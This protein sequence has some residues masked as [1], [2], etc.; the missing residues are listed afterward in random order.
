MF[1]SGTACGGARRPARASVRVLALPLLLLLAASP[2]VVQGQGLRVNGTA[3]NMAANGGRAELERIYGA[4]KQWREAFKRS[5]SSA[6]QGNG[7]SLCAAGENDAAD[8]VPYAQLVVAASPLAYSSADPA[9]TGGLNLVPAARDQRPCA[10][11]TAFAA[12]AAAQAAIAAVLRKNARDIEPLS[13]QDLM[14]CG[15]DAPTRCG[16]G[17]TLTEALRQLKDRAVA[18]EA[19]LPYRPPA[20]DAKRAPPE[21]AQDGCTGDGGD[22]MAA[23]LGQAS[24]KQNQRRHQQ[25]AQGVFSFQPLVEQWVME[26]HIREHGAVVSRFD[27]MDDFKDFFADPKNAKKVYTPKPGAKMVE[28][29]A[30]TIVG[31]DISEKSWLC[32]NSWGPNWADGGLFRVAWRTASIASPTDTYG[33]TWEPTFSLARQLADARSRFLKAMDSKPGCFNYTAQKGDFVFSISQRFSVP[34][35]QVLLENAPTIGDLDVPL[36]GKSLTLCNLQTPLD[37]NLAAFKAALR[38]NQVGISLNCFSYPS[39]YVLGVLDVLRELGLFTPTTKTASIGPTNGCLMCAGWGIDGAI[40][41]YDDLRH[42]CA[43]A[44]LCMRKMTKAASNVITA[45]LPVAGVAE[46][47]SGV[48]G[49]GLSELPPG[50][51][52]THN[53]GRYKEVITYDSDED[54]QQ[55]MLAASY[56]PVVS[57][58]ANDIMYRSRKTTSGYNALEGKQ[59]PCPAGVAYCLRVNCAPPPDFM[60]NHMPIET[61]MRSLGKARQ[62]SPAYTSFAA[63]FTTNETAPAPRNA[64]RAPAPGAAQREAA[65]RAAAAAALETEPTAEELRKAGELGALMGVDIAPGLFVPL[66]LDEQEAMGTVM[67]PPVDGMAEWMVDM[68]RKDA[69]LWAQLWGVAGGGGGAAA[70]APPRKAAAGAAAAAKP[71]ATAAAAAK[72]AVPAAVAKPAVATAVAAPKPAVA[73]AVAAPKPAASAAAAVPKPIAAAAAAAPKTTAA[74]RVIPKPALAP[75]PPAAAG[76][77]TRLLPQAAAPRR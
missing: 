6:C 7:R 9:S 26:A 24:S 18:T 1:S 75:P 48:C 62:M 46:K 64:A 70:A 47:C 73:T 60:P 16:D 31:Y 15:I 42:Q 8:T 67:L 38:H 14:Y 27:I 17:W 36:A 33:V 29:H 52:P 61:A 65:A 10:S 51:H 13:T 54:F 58:G 23:L 45:H 55:A 12:A 4:S 68:G 74:A 22:V 32:L 28:P 37:K 56:F 77:P 19:C 49:M 3:I 69:R 20:A 72:A 41:A 44:N 35:N 39:Y 50:K 11:C 71:A 57:D 40:K 76:A 34:L 30:V 2:S 53:R 21:C 43:N 66:A 5:P 59:P 25:A 63:V